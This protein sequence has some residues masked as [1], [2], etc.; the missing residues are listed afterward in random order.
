MRRSSLF[1]SIHYYIFLVPPLVHLTPAFNYSVDCHN[2]LHNYKYCQHGALLHHVYTLSRRTCSPSTALLHVCCRGVLPMFI[3]RPLTSVV[4]VHTLF[5]HST[6]LQGWNS[7]C[8]HFP[9]SKNVGVGGDTC[10][11]VLLTIDANL[12]ASTP[13][14]VVLVCGENNFPAD[15]AEVTFGQMSQLVRNPPPKIQTLKL[16]SCSQR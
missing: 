4:T 16:C 10:A 1:V 6:Q 7:N 3:S 11:D 13:E 2:L 14:W 9:E 15:S 12:A 5:S 8:C